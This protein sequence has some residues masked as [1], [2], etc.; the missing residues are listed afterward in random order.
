MCVL[1]ARGWS[2]E[3]INRSRCY[4]H[5]PPGAFESAAT[6]S[7]AGSKNNFF[8]DVRPLLQR[9]QALLLLATT[10]ATATAMVPAEPVPHV[11]PTGAIPPCF[12]KWGGVWFYWDK[13]L[14]MAALLPRRR[15]GQRLC[16][17]EHGRLPRCR[18][19]Q[20][21]R[22]NRLAKPLLQPRGRVTSVF[23]HHGDSTSKDTKLLL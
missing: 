20:Q 18:P 7:A 21:R 3:W 8:R 13:G 5:F 9:A 10:A 2:R 1:L 17:H 6:P 23:E 16:A 15:P 19:R 14:S 12:C 4:R 22:A 11:E